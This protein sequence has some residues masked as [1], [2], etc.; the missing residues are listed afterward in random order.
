MNSS[1]EN[2]SAAQA[3]NAIKEYWDRMHSHSQPEPFAVLFESAAKLV[4]GKLSCKINPFSKNFNLDDPRFFIICSV[5]QFHTM[6]D[7]S[8]D[9]KLIQIVS[10]KLFCVDLDEGFS[11]LPNTIYLY[12][13]ELNKV[14]LKGLLRQA[15]IL[16]QA[17]ILDIGKKIENYIISS[18]NKSPNFL[19]EE[20]DKI[21]N[22]NVIKNKKYYHYT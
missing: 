17:E 16:E 4:D 2:F 19:Y 20:V 9:E 3:E 6:L 11:T 10:N 18:Y 12:D 1:I 21:Y 8:M 13:Q 22:N 7:W 5:E 14:V 15:D